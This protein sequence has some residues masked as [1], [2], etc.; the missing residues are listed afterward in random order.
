MRFARA[1]EKIILTQCSLAGSV[2]TLPDE[3]IFGWD[4]FV[5]FPKEKFDGSP[6]DR[7]PRKK[8][9]VKV[10]STITKYGKSKIKLSNIQEAV[11]SHDPWFIFMVMKDKTIRGIHVWGDLLTSW[12]KLIRKSGIDSKELHKEKLIFTFDT[13]TQIH[14]NV[15][16][17]MLNE[18]DTVGI[19]YVDAKTKVIQTSGYES[20]GATGKL[21]LENIDQDK[22]ARAFLGLE[23]QIPVS[24]FSITR[25]RFGLSDPTPFVDTDK[26]LLTFNPNPVEQCELRFK[27]PL[28]E[29]SIAMSGDIYAYKPI[30]NT[31]KRGY[32]RFSAPPLEIVADSNG[33]YDFNFNFEEAGRLPFSRW[34]SYATIISWSSFG[35][36][37][38]KITSRDEIFVGARLDLTPSEIHHNIKR[39]CAVVMAIRDAARTANFAAPDFEIADFDNSAEQADAFAA[40]LSNENL[41]GFWAP[42]D[43]APAKFTSLAYTTVVS[44]PHLSIGCVITRTILTDETLEGTRKVS[45]GPPVIRE[46]IFR[47]HF[48]KNMASSLE[49][50]CDGLISAMDDDERVLKVEDFHDAIRPREANQLTL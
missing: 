17:W 41:Y 34:L 43:D 45:A 23:K 16:E 14:Q 13:S 30:T 25:T 37:D 11:T 28:T 7:P 31:T 38:V 42:L 48:S 6:E 50:F 22:L 32:I 46:A 2:A 40:A 44:F 8:A 12:L 24:Q 18:I 33:K 29:P 4:L 3:D 20:G 15:S 36:V 9:Y 49:A 1:A 21:L 26:G 19:N 10:K 35:P 39:L 47:P 5:E 27:G